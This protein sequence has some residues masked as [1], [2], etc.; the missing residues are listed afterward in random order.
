MEFSDSSR[1]KLFCCVWIG[2]WFDG[3]LFY[4]VRFWLRIYFKW[5]FQVRV[6]LCVKEIILSCSYRVAVRWIFLSSGLKGSGRVAGSFQAEF[7]GSVLVQ[8]DTWTNIWTLLDTQTLYIQTHKH[9]IS[10]RIRRFEIFIHLILYVA[11]LN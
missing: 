4:G 7:S 5:S 3:I 8:H 1:R 2:L 11:C 6:G 9:I 10:I